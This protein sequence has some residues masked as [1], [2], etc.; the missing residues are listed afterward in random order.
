MA[1]PI[2]VHLLMGYLMYIFFDWSVGGFGVC[3]LDYYFLADSLVNHVATFSEPFEVFPRDYEALTAFIN[4]N[5]NCLQ[6]SQLLNFFDYNG[7]EDLA[8]YVRQG[9]IN[10]IES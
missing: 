2:F 4:T 7:G 9:L 1:F 3:I 6:G 5:A 10:G 8:P